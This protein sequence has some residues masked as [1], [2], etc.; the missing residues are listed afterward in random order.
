MTI[1]DFSAQAEAYERSRPGYPD[2]LV[3]R[4]IE[5][6]RLQ[7]GD[8]VVDFGAGTGI[9]TRLLCQR[10]FRVTALEPNAAMRQKAAVPEA[11]WGEGSFEQSGLPN[12]SQAWAGATF[13]SRNAETQ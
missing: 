4:L 2:A 13:R 6:L 11:V 5:Q 3:H 10:G 9:F 1:G 12:E 8:P 7:P